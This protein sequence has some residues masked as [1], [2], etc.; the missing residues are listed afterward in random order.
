MPWLLTAVAHGEPA[1]VLGFCVGRHVG[2]EPAPG[3]SVTAMEPVMEAVHLGPVR[4]RCDPGEVVSAALARLGAVPVAPG[5]GFHPAG[6][7]PLPCQDQ[8]SPLQFHALLLYNS[9]RIAA[10]PVVPIRLTG[11]SM[12]R[13]KRPQ[14]SP[15]CTRASAS[16]LALFVPY[17]CHATAYVPWMTRHSI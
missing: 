7:R 3:A 13:P 16:S 5:P 17:A 12:N 4:A 8:G 6:R 1:S 2:L 10:H 9:P 14:T 15:A 11:R